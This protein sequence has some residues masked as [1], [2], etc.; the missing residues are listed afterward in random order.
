M[1]SEIKRY[2]LSEVISYIEYKMRNGTDTNGEEILYQEFHTY[3]NVSKK[4]HRET[5]KELIREM[6]E[7]YG[8]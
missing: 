3:G 1:D 5:L 8:F 7:E 2:S 6:R 4:K